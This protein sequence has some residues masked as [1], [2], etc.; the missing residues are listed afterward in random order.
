MAEKKMSGNKG[1]WSELYV[2]LKALGD[3]KIY[4]ADANLNKKPNIYLD[5]NKVLRHDGHQNLDFIRIPEEDLIRVLKNSEKYTEVDIQKIIDE[6]RYLLTEIRRGQNSFE[7]PHTEAF[8]RSI[9]CTT[10]KAPSKDKTDITMEIHEYRT[11]MDLIQGFSIKS[12][13]GEKPTLF[14]ASKKTNFVFR[15]KGNV[16]DDIVEEANKYFESKVQEKIKKGMKVLKTNDIELEFLDTVDDTLY[17][18]LC[19]VDSFAPRIVAE[20]LIQYYVNGN[21]WV[22]DISNQLKIDDPVKYRGNKDYP[23]YKVKIKKLLTAFALGL[24][25][26]TKWDGY[27]ETNGGYI[28]V[29]SNGDIL[30]YHIYDR[31]DFENY[32]INNTY[33]ETPSTSRHE[34]ARIYRENDEYR[35]KLNLQIRFD[36]K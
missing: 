29:K 4:T 9:G 11:G 30:C 14:N 6:Y 8:V 31:M 12:H 2:F 32:L 34:F 22:K 20:M 10:I 5:V 3:G 16:N 18:N 28:V 7:I 21:K 36:K 13:L 19:M 26:D 1:D 35:I 17:N 24:L 33:L 25:P 27:E 23:L 15:L